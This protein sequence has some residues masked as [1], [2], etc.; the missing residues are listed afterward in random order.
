MSF[1]EEDFFIG[2][3]VCLRSYNSGNSGW[4]Q[5]DIDIGIVMEVIEIDKRFEYYDKRFRCYDIVVFWCNRN[6]KDTVPDIMLEHYE[7]YVRRV[8]EKRLR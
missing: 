1:C 5:S 4:Y 8:N 2:D 6:T 7:R 3:L